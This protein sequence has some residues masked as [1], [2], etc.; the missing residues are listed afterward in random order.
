MPSIF[1]EIITGRIPGQIVWQDDNHVALLTIEPINE[2]HTMVIPRKEVENWTDMSQEEYADLMVACKKVAERL[3][4]V[5][6]KNKVVQL[7][8]GFEVAHVHVH[9]IP[10]DN[11]AECPYPPTTQPSAQELQIVADKIRQ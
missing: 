3:K 9:L 7:I 1:S 4:I 6:N 10:A 11:T 5:F 8:Q 2:G